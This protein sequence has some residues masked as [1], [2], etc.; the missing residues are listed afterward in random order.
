MLALYN[1]ATGRLS[2]ADWLLTTLARLVFAGTLLMYFWASGL[3]KLG[4]GVF[5]LFDQP[6]NL[7]SRCFLLI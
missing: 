4:D 6:A 1:A 7:F 2:R 5:G 3:T